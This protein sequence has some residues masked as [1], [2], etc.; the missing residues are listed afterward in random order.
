[1][2]SARA[3]ER[4]LR[5]GVVDFMSDFI[6]KRM[7]LWSNLNLLDGVSKVNGS[8]TLQLREQ[9]RVQ[10]LLYATPDTDLPRLADFLAVSHQTEKGKIIEWSE[11]RTCLP[12]ITAGQRPVFASDEMTLSALTNANF[13][14]SVVVYLPT[15]A[16]SQIN[17]RQAATARIVRRQFSAQRVDIDVEASGPTLVVV[18]QSFYHCWRPYV[19]EKPARLLRANYAFQAVEVPAGPHQVKLVYEDRN[20]RFGALLSAATFLACLAFWWR[21]NSK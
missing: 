7:A 16:E 8:A 17:A 5:S 20:L 3:E 13:D 9:A 11:R 18:A 21:A 19:D 1:M 12:M 10:A 6:G 2:I 15:A 14:G 4:L